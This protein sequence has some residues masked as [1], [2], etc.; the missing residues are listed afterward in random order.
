MAQLN[1]LHTIRNPPYVSSYASEYQLLKLQLAKED[2]GAVLTN[3]AGSGTP[4]NVFSEEDENIDVVTEDDFDDVSEKTKARAVKK[5]AKMAKNF[6]YKAHGFTDSAISRIN[7]I[8]ENRR[9]RKI[10]AIIDKAKNRKTITGMLHNGIKAAG[11]GAM[12]AGLAMVC[13][14]AAVG[15]F[16]VSSHINNEDKKTAIEE[17]VR[18]LKVI[19]LQIQKADR[20]GDYDKKADLIIAK[21]VAEEAY[22]K[23]KYGLK[24]LPTAHSSNTGS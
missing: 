22:H 9:E 14:P 2:A 8:P 21:R 23:L 1:K 4:Y 15:V 10:K 3:G 7:E 19:D 5:S 24:H 16:L 6:S 17:I 13:L 12:Y 20:D 11:T 18:E